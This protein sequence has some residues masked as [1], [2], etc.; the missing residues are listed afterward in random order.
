MIPGKND[1]RWKE[2]VTST[3]EFPL[4]GLATKMLVMRVRTI[5]KLD[6]SPAKITEAISIAHEYFS[7][8]E[9]M[10]KADLEVLFGKL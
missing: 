7:K 1:P 2:I 6:Q 8:N 3:K 10:L 5:V 9:E 4:S